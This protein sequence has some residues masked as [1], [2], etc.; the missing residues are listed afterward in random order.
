MN[1]F[2]GVIFSNFLGS[3]QIMKNKF[4]NHDQHLWV[5]IQKKVLNEKPINY[6]LPQ[7]K[8]NI[9]AYKI[10]KNFFFKKII[11]FALLLNVI[12][13]SIYYYT[14]SLEYK[15]SISLLP[16]L[17]III[18]GLELFFESFAY[19]FF[20]LIRFRKGF[21]K[22]LIVVILLI[23]SLLNFTFKNFFNKDTMEGRIL[24]IFILF[25]IFIFIRLFKKFK[26]LKRLAKSLLSSSKYIFSII[27]LLIIIFSIYAIIGCFLFGN[28]TKGKVINKYI[29]F[30]NF[31]NALVTLFTCSTFDN[32]S[33]IMVDC[34]NNCIGED[35]NCGSSWSTIYFFSFIFLVGQ[36]LLNMIILILMQAFEEFYLNPDQ[37]LKLYHDYIKKFKLFWSKF[38]CK[39]FIFYIDERSI[40]PFYRSLGKPLGFSKIS[41]I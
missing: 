3:Q 2:I 18:Y 4:L 14:A 36:I 29:N 41:Y 32:W 35:I 24:K 27:V 16:N 17:L 22:I 28:I 11:D 31:F 20:G 12:Y 30:N 6:V 9:T 23:E 38:C 33:A 10:V 7:K 25:H 8:I 5:D 15:M 39:D 1:F 37:P 34:S 21:S 19:G 13:L 26:N 40:I